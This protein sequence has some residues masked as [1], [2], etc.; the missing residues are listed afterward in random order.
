VLAASDVLAGG[1]LAMRSP[2]FLPEAVMRLL[3]ETQ[4]WYWA[5]GIGVGLVLVGA[6]GSRASKAMVKSGIATVAI[7]VL[8][9]LLAW[10]VVTPAERLYAVHAELAAATKEGGKGVERLF[11]HLA[12]DFEC[13]QLGV[14]NLSEAKSLIAARLEPL[15]VKSNYVR[16]YRSDVSGE[17][18]RTLVTFLTESD[19]GLTKTSWEL[20]WQDVP[21]SDWKMRSAELKTVNDAKVSELGF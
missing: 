8:W 17:T 13:Q 9:V 2:Q 12:S 16:A 14:R 18:A 7:T 4:V 6:G 11:S 10:L 19:M 1:M 3:F 20:R 21:G 5:F 15:H